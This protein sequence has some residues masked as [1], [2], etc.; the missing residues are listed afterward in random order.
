METHT[1]YVEDGGLRFLIHVLA[2]LSRKEKARKQQGKSAP[3]NPFLPYDPDL[4]VTDISPTHLCLLNKFNVV[5]NH[6]LIVT[7][8]Y[9]PQEHWLTQGD[10]EAIAHCVS[11]LDGL[12][13]F[14]GGTAAGASQP[15]K[16]VQ[17]NPRD[18]SK[19]RSKEAYS[20]VFPIEG[21]IQSASIQTAPTSDSHNTPLKST[22]LPFHHAI[23]P[24]E[25]S[26]SENLSSQSSAEDIKS[27]AAQY[28]NSYHMLLSAVG[29]TSRNQWQGTQSAPYNFLCTRHWMMIVPRSQE[30]HAGISVNS[31]GF[32]GS[33]LVK[34]SAT[35]EEL[36]TMG[37][38]HLLRSVS[39][40][41]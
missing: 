21:I 41:A 34:D 1:E 14:N 7:R 26:N 27:I 24:L 3:A 37:P 8:A 40:Q 17:D 33:L 29:I 11:E 32:V 10:F 36:K 13:F 4:Y 19:S 23:L 25:N 16:H 30:K 20:T 38:L 39:C 5:D 12:V 35:L 2:N 28:L 31:L 18:S 6:F 22:D 9:E 15:H